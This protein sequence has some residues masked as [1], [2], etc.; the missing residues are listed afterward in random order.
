[1]MK[2]TMLNKIYQKHGT[3][4]YDHGF[5]NF[6]DPYFSELNER[7][8]YHKYLELGIYEGKSLSAY[9]EFCKDAE[10]FGIDILTDAVNAGYERV[11]EGHFFLCNLDDEEQLNSCIRV[12]KTLNFKFDVILDDCSH[13]WKQQYTNMLT[14]EQ[15]LDK[16]GYYILEDLHTST[17]MKD[18]FNNLDDC[19]LFNNED[20]TKFP[21]ISPLRFLTLENDDIEMNQTLRDLRQKMKNVSVYYNTF[22]HITSVIQFS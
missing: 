15:L 7:K 1:M 14:F 13:T 12:F 10:I 11:P 5:G 2:D 18:S 9:K 3:D 22:E 8:P 17:Y 21:Y 6:Y 16:D 20:N 19:E 4:K